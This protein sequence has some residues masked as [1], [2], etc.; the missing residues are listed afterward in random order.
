MGP[1][2]TE[3]TKRRDFFNPENVKV[4]PFKLDFVDSEEEDH[5]AA[6]KEIRKDFSGF[7]AKIMNV[8]ISDNLFPASGTTMRV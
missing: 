1:D 2:S 8:S 7:T 6:M 5:S 3:K 4:P